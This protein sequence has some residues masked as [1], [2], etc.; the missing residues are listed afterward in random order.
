MGR[1]CGRASSV[2]IPTLLWLHDIGHFIQWSY[3]GA[4]LIRLFHELARAGEGHHTGNKNQA[5]YFGIDQPTPCVKMTRDTII[6]FTPEKQPF[7]A[8]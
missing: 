1:F 4:E 2:I 3:S 6:I 8:T 5:D 7:A